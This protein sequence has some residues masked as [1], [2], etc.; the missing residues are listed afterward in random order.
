[1]K[2]IFVLLILAISLVCRSSTSYAAMVS[3]KPR[4]YVRD[5]H[6]AYP[7]WITSKVIKKANKAHKAIC[8]GKPK[9]YWIKGK[10][11]KELRA[12]L[13]YMSGVYLNYQVPDEWIIGNCFRGTPGK[14]EINLHPK[15]YLKLR[16]QDR[17]V[18]DRIKAAIRQMQIHTFWSEPDAVKAV[19]DWICKA[20]NYDYRV[21]DDK[22]LT[23]NYKAYQ[24]LKQGIV[25][26][27]GYADLFQLFMNELGIRGYRVESDQ[28]NHIWNSVVIDGKT[29]YVDVCWNDTSN[30]GAWLLADRFMDHGT[31]KC[32]ISDV[33]SITFTA[34]R[35][36]YSER[37]GK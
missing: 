19:N 29:E 30:N 11:T 4:K 6:K 26:C 34:K 2:K 3:M 36:F 16:K 5:T 35:N 18:R 8:H 10:T 12:V 25:V 33:P 17:Y 32:H 37:K 22:A 31:D 13:A 28:I 9:Q 7:L 21:Y 27:E 24:G 14:Y 20:V 1:M 15:L 23:F